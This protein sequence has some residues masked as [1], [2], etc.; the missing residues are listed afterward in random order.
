MPALS[1]II[2]Q[3]L[4]KLMSFESMML[5]NQHMFCHPLLFLPSV[6]PSIRVF[7]NESATQLFVSGGLSTRALASASV[8]PMNNQGWFP[9]GLTGL[10]SLQSKW[11]SRVFSS[12]TVWKHQFFIKKVLSI[13]Y[14]PILTSYDYW[15]KYS[16]DYGDLCQQSD[17]CFL[18]Y[19]LGLSYFSFQGG[20]V[21]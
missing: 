5:S 10:I 17:I 4:L 15:E 11:L 8:L 13:P 12:T 2:T 1:F 14:G 20:R 3:S 18:I 21:F 9:L 6:F 16:F 19:S 7:S